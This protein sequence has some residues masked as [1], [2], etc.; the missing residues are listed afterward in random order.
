M[1]PTTCGLL[2]NRAYHLLNSLLCR[3]D[4]VQ[5]TPNAR[6]EPRP[7]VG[8]RQERGGLLGVGCSAW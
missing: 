7:I 4:A 5:M 2:S 1:M 8:A 3:G 6:G